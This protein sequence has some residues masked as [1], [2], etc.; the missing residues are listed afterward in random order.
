MNRELARP[1]VTRDL[2][3]H[4]K[5]LKLYQCTPVGNLARQPRAGHYNSYA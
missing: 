1:S 3:E 4:G 2:S 5:D